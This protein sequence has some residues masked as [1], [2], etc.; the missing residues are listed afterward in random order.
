MKFARIDIE[1]IGFVNKKDNTHINF[2]DH[3]QNIVIKDLYKYMN[4]SEDEIVCLDFNKI[5]TYD[6]EY[7]VLPINQAISHNLNSFLSHKIIPVF[8]GISRDTTA[9][10]ED[11]ERYLNQFSP[12]GCRDQSIFD[13]LVKKNIPCYL[14]GCIT[15][16]MNARKQQPIDGVPYVIEAPEYAINNMPLEMKKKAY[17]SENTFYGT[18]N[19]LVGDGTLEEYIRARYQDIKEHASVV[20][21]SRMHIASPCIGMGV[22]VVLVRKSIDYRFSWIDK[23]IPIYTEKDV[24]NINWYP[25]AITEI[26]DIKKK[27]VEY[28]VYRIRNTY[29]QS[30]L[31]SQISEFYEERDKVQ[32]DL[33]QFSKGVIDYVNNKWKKDDKFRYA[34]WGENDASERLYNY[35]KTNYKNAEFVAFYDSYKMI[36]YHGIKAQHP[37]QIKNDDVF[38]FVTGYTATDAAREMF[39]NMNRSEDSYYLFGSVVRGY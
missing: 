24:N 39:Q 11:E 28:S 13:F 5:S 3:L 1:T 2:G 37:R 17:F 29:E 26:E 8:L 31:K 25:E 32:Y 16:T 21:T 6:G 19:E 35:L 9:I 18:Y 27:I 34:I 36:T 12:I 14:S 15:L 23:Y 10:T 20:I 30:M 38:V 22:P 4:I 7:I 33:P